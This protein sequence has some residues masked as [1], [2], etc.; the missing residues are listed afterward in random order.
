[1]VKKRSGSVQV[2]AMQP[3]AGQF[4]SCSLSSLSC[5]GHVPGRILETERLS[6]QVVD[7]ILK[8]QLQAR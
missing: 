3:V 5:F 7:L 6:V 2:A 1:M 8:E 4:Q